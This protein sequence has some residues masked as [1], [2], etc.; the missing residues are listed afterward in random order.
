MGHFDDV[1]LSN[2]RSDDESFQEYKDRIKKN[3]IKI[4]MHLKGEIIWESK[5]QGPMIK[6]KKHGSE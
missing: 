6:N 1:N 4:Q 5:I 2:K 3:K